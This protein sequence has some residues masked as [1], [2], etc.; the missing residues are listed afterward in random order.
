MPTPLNVLFIGEESAG[1]LT[2]KAIAG[3]RH[4]VVAVMTAPPG[5]AKSIFKVW[6][7]AKDLG[8]ETFPSNLVK[9]PAFATEVRSRDVDIILNVHSLFIIN[10][11]ILKASRIGAR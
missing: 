5:K 11:E 7:I 2:L 6:D 1:I 3:T 10:G 4:R 9:D 8:Y